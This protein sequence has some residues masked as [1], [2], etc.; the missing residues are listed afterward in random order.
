[1]AAEVSRRLGRYRRAKQRSSA[2]S[3]VNIDGNG[4]VRRSRGR[5]D[6]GAVALVLD[7]A[8]AFGRVSLPV[9]W[10][11][12]AHF[13][14][15]RKILRVLCGYLEHQRRVQFE[16]CVAKPLQTITAILPGSKWSCLL[17]RIVLQDALSEV[18]KFYPPLKLRVFEDDTTAPLIDRKK[19]VAEM[20][21][22]VMKKLEEEVEK[23]G[24]QIVGH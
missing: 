22:K 16:G 12:A 20:A 18:T 1:M 11:R 17:L 4:E 21:K 23:K 6:E 13:S 3:L 14:F 2:D 8:K 7:M 9:V 24:P 19:K 5:K 10:A 15:Q